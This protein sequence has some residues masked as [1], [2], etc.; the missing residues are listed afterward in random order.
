MTTYSYKLTL[1]V[2]EAITLKE[3]LRLYVALCTRDAPAEFR[4]KCGNWVAAEA[5]C[6]DY[7]T[8]LK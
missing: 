4:P 1:N 5:I 2:T 8:M 6:T 7:I 3:A